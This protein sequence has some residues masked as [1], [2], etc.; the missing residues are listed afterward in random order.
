[1]KRIINKI[2]NKLVDLSE[3]VYY[4]VQGNGASL[5]AILACV[6]IAGYLLTVLF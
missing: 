1:M 4:F 6:A 3:E 5:V 2:T